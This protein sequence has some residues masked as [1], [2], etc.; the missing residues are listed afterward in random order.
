MRRPSRTNSLWSMEP[1][2]SRS[3]MSNTSCARWR[4]YADLRG[5][6]ASL[7]VLS[8]QSM[9]NSLDKE[10]WGQRG[11]GKGKTAEERRIETHRNRPIYRRE[12]ERDTHTHTTRSNPKRGGRCQ[13]VSTPA[14]LGIVFDS[15]FKERAT[16]R[17]QFQCVLYGILF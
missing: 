12:R 8:R 4:R 3:N 10:G 1:S 15:S 7:R 17:R 2:W 13:N 5:S 14:R 9:R 16:K 6:C 11:T